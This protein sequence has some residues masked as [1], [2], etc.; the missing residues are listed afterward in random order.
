MER[1]GFMAQFVSAQEAVKHIKSGD[2]VVLA[3]SIGEPQALVNAMMDNYKS[4]KDV[5]ICHMLA[6]GPCK[7]AQPGMEGHFR[8]NSLFAGPG[9]RQALAERR[10]DFTPVY[11][12]ETPRLFKNG[13]LPVDVAMVTVSPPDE[14]GYCTLGVAVDYSK[15]AVDNAKIVIAQVNKYMPKTYGDTLVHLN[16]IDFAVECDEPLFALNSPA[17]TEIEDKIGANCASLIKDGD[18]LQLG[19]GG[20]PNAVLSYLGD[21]NDMGIHSEMLSNG[22]MDLLEKG[23]INNSKK[24]IHLG[25]SIVTFLYAGEKLYNYVNNNPSV[26]FYP[27]DYVNNPCV[28]GQNDN[29][30][31]VNSALSVDLWGQVVADNVNEVRQYSGAGGFVDFVRGASFSKGGRS[32][33]A[34]P[35]TAAGGKASRIVPEFEAGRPITLSRFDVDYIVTEYGVAPLRGKN[36]RERSRSLIEIAHPDFRDGMKEKYEK[37]FLEK[38]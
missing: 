9:S 17:N 32:I 25:K 14:H 20:I 24:T 29:L 31:S 16:D 10:A 2:R 19:I 38:Y 34:M 23:N 35:S 3:H 30:V 13:Y 7:Y 5:E 1:K 37:R 8:H 27:V 21:K 11:F 36:W 26:E 6:L 33:I 15:A 12:F 22:V 18:C 4:Y 28:V